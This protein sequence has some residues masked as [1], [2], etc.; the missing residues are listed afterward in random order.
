MEI[1]WH[2]K[3]YKEMEKLEK[4][5][6]ERILDKIE[7]MVNRPEH[8]L[9]GLVGTD[10]YKLRIGDY[11]IIVDWQRK[12]N[13]ITILMVGKRSKIYDELEKF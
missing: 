4:K 5:I 10:F 1:R 11:R 9:E 3:A 7:E 12:E 2:R 8:F 13:I 6:C